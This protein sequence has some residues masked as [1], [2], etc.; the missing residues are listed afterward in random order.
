MAGRREPFTPC[1]LYIDG[2]AGLSVGDFITTAR[3]SAYLVQAVRPSPSKPER[4]YLQCLRWVIDQIPPA[5]RR[6]ELTW[7]RR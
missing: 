6:Y 5:A 1:Q 4:V 3:G 7:Y 2:A